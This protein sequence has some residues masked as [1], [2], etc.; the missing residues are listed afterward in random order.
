[1]SGARAAKAK[2]RFSNFEPR[3]SPHSRFD[4]PSPPLTSEERRRFSGFTLMELLTVIVIISILLVLLAPAFTTRKSADDVTSAANGIKGLLDTART[5][6]KANNTYVFVGLVEVKASVDPPVAGNGRVAIAVV[7]SKDGARHFQYTK[8]GQGSDW[9]A[10]YNNG[11]NLTAITKLQVYENLHFSGLNFGIWLPL[12]HPTSNM[13]RPSPT[14]S[15]TAGVT[16]NLGTSSSV[17]PFSW[18]L[19][20]SQYNFTKVINFDP[21]G[22][23]RIAGLTNA[24]EVTY[25]IE[26]DFQQ[27]HG[28]AVPAAPS[29]QDVGNQFVIQIDAPTGAVRL[30]RP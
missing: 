4:I 13:A 14:P 15:Q 16:Y 17:T 23:A 6:A 9:T 20:S 12:S 19:G 21:S 25:V 22:V 5:Y 26:I 11:A 2:F 8:S 27:S 1:V 24:D 10:G 28:T 18:P 30:Y 29:N 3:S 7:A